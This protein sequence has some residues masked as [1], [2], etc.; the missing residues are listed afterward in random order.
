MNLIQ[1]EGT[2][3]DETAPTAGVANTGRNWME[4]EAR[5]LPSGYNRRRYRRVLSRVQS[6]PSVTFSTSRYQS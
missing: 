2:G 1:G 4:I 6:R 5:S 3:L